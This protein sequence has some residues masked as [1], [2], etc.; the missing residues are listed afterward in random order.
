MIA[1]RSSLSFLL[2]TASLSACGGDL[3]DDGGGDSGTTSSITGV[4]GV[5]TTTTGG[6]GG[7][8]ESAS[9]AADE[10][11]D[12]P[13]STGEPPDPPEPPAM[14]LD[15]SNEYGELSLSGQDIE[16][17]PETVD[18]G[19]TCGLPGGQQVYEILVWRPRDPGA[20]PAED[21]WPEPI[22]AAGSPIGLPWVLLQH[23][24]GQIAGG[25]DHIVDPLVA[26]GFVVFAINDGSVGDPVTP[27]RVARMRCALDWITEQYADRDHLGACYGLIG[28]SNGGA[29][30]LELG[31]ALASDNDPLA[32]NLGAVVAITPFEIEPSPTDF[33]AEDN[34][35]LLVV[36]GSHDEDEELGG[37]NAYEIIGDEGRLNRASNAAGSQAGRVG[38]KVLVEAFS[39]THNSWGGTY[40]VGNPIFPEEEK[41]EAIAAAYVPAFLEWQLLGDASARPRFADNQIPP[42]LDSATWWSN[43]PQWDGDPLIN[44]AY[45]MGD[46]RGIGIERLP[47]ATFEGDDEFFPY[48][49][50]AGEPAP[51]PDLDEVLFDRQDA[52]YGASGLISTSENRAMRVDWS[53]E[54]SVTLDF[55]APEFSNSPT[56]VSLRVH[57]VFD[58][59]VSGPPDC[60]PEPSEAP[61][62]FGL[63]MLDEAGT[64]GSATIEAIVQ[65]YSEAPELSGPSTCDASQTLYTARVP[66]E[67]MDTNSGVPLQADNIQSVQLRFGGASGSASG[68]VVVD[69]IE[70]SYSPEDVPV[71][72]AE[73]P[74]APP[75]LSL[76]DYMCLDY[77]PDGYVGFTSSSG[78]G[79]TIG[80]VVVDEKLT[81]YIS[82]RPSVVTECDDARYE[83]DTV[84][85][86]ADSDGTPDASHD[87]R[88]LNGVDP[89]DLVALL[90]LEESDGAVTLNEPGKPAE[91]AVELYDYGS[92][93]AAYSRF[94]GLENLEV[95]FLREGASGLHE[96]VMIEA[97]VPGRVRAPQPPATPS[98]FTLPSGAT[99]VS[100]SADL[101]NAL[102]LPTGQDIIVADGDYTWT[103][104][105]TVAGPHRIWAQTLHGATIHFGLTYA[106]NADRT[107]GLE[108]HGLA[109]E[110]DDATMAPAGVG[111]THILFTW[112]QGGEDVLVEDCTFDGDLTIGDAIGAFAPSGL[113]VRRSEFSNFWGYGVVA[114]QGAPGTVLASEPLLED[115]TISS[116]FGANPGSS[117]GAWENGLLLGN[118]GTIRRVDIR[119][120]GWSGI[121]LYNDATGVSIED[122][123]IDYA[124]PGVWG[125]TYTQARGAGIWLA[126]SH[127]VQIARVRIESHVFLGINVHWDQ[128]NSDPFLNTTPPRNHN[129]TISDLYSRAYKIGVH[130]DLGV[131]DTVIRSSRFEHAWMAGILDNNQFEDDWGWHPCP[132]GEEV[133]LES[134]NR[135]EGVD[136][137]LQDG[138]DCVA[139]HHNG[140]A[141]ATP[142][143]GWPSHPSDYVQPG[144]LWNRNGAAY[145][146]SSS[147]GGSTGGQ[148]DSS[149]SN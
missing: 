11:G 142:P 134:P 63:Q 74:L 31:R 35:P 39:V 118:N 136:C 98:P 86:D 101:V 116:V 82:A 124:G 96:P 10:T 62:T 83:L 111:S 40:D 139:H 75:P 54:G 26:Q 105:V 1:P 102:A 20:A 77:D 106:G 42:G 103:G 110:L 133:C 131:E 60:D 8:D 107:G 6:T 78:P 81:R 23:G 100:S 114:K 90:G 137:Y 135:S 91:N 64:I 5:S 32:Q 87:V 69:S 108:L 104:P 89:T 46:R 14:T 21:G 143:T 13:G 67:C 125:S 51:S 30:A 115:L 41:G 95:R 68:E 12:P 97:D 92:F 59:W 17:E 61:L 79:E 19:A 7:Q 109:F 99:V 138:V 33:D 24:N 18:F 126:Q 73:V 16:A 38:E 112:G 76:L 145:P 146:S 147:G 57:N 45:Q 84:S 3:V 128:G 52:L 140:G 4:T 132:G 85:V 22:N 80:E 72:C 58:G 36:M 2:V 34:Y 66:I 9:E 88:T 120:V 29:G 93:L 121:Q 27:T 47:V 53:E 65:D 49:G 144:G 71:S 113:T 50:V 15:C 149:T 130:L 56:H 122:V 94:S 119:D 43:S 70:L 44:T 37:Y 123:Y 127:D 129:I 25:Y 117:N 28:H 141:N 48:P 148:A 55:G